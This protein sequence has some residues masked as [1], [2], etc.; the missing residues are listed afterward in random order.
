MM[1]LVNIYWGFAT[2]QAVF[3]DFSTSELIWFSQQPYP[4]DTIIILLEEETE[5]QRG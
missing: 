5:A 3:H 2:C 1:I 4:V